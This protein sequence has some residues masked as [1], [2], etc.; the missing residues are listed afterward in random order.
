MTESASPPTDASP[1]DGRTE[2]DASPVRVVDKRWWA[3][4]GGGRRRP[5]RRHGLREA[6]I[7]GRTSSGNWR[8]RRRS[9]RSTPPSTR[10]RPRTSTRYANACAG[11]RPRT[12][13]AKSASSSP[14]SWR[15]STI[16]SGRSTRRSRQRTRRRER[17]MAVLTGVGLV[18]DQCL[19]TLSGFGVT[20]VDT[21]GQRFDPNVH[22]A[23]STG[24]VQDATQ[25]DTVVAVAK[26]GYMVGGR[27][28]AAGERGRWGSWKR[29]TRPRRRWSALPTRVQVALHNLVRTAQT[30]RLESECGYTSNRWTRC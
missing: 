29:S 10:V 26:P 1:A 4:R 25:H 15:S 14:R 6:C 3:T 8:P 21:L 24:P 19:K 20:R 12:S 7:R 30:T 16:S 13:S 23:L 9:S 11:S 28:A 17:T 22:D 18:R 2:D 27:S 5:S